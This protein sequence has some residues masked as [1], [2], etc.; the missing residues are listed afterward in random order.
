MKKVLRLPLTYA[1]AAVTVWALVIGA[2]SV[3]ETTNTAQENSSPGVVDP[4]AQNVG[5]AGYVVHIDPETGGITD[6]PHHAVPLVLDQALQNALDT[7]SEDLVEV[8]SPVAGGG[9][10]VDLQG[11]FQNTMIVT[12]DSSDRLQSSCVSDVTGDSKNEAEKE[13][14]T[15]ADEEE[16]E[17][18]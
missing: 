8:P 11:R 7:S 9:V 6:S 4:A 1:L 10:V 12:V 18:R 5:A 15:V 13:T 3:S 14:D 16:G 2:G 17:R